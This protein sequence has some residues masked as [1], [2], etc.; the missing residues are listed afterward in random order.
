M[1][2]AILLIAGVV[3]AI[4]IW[5]DV[6]CRRIPNP[7]VLAITLLGLIRLGVAGDLPMALST[8]A[9][10]GAVFVVA[11]AMFWCGWLGG[12]DAKLLPAATILVGVHGLPVF[13]LLMSLAG[14]VLSI[15]VLSAAKF[16]GPFGCLLPSAAAAEIPA[17]PTV[18]YGV[19]IALAGVAVLILQNA[20]IR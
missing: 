13:L 5:D 12:G 11:F 9:A 18:P 3:F 8:L 1:Q 10:A 16:G 17:R 7:L 14:A 6:R 4:I 20:P 15:A 2:K 19:A